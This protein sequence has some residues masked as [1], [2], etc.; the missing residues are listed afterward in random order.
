MMK[1]GIVHQETMTIMSMYTRIT[2]LE[3]MK[4]MLYKN[5]I[6]GKFVLGQTDLKLMRRKNI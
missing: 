1:K 2:Q 5:I 3:N 4:Q 6:E